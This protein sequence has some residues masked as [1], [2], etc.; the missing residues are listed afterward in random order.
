MGLP[1]LPVLAGV[2]HL[3]GQI[4]SPSSLFSHSSVNLALA[5]R[6]YK[7]TPAIMQQITVYETVLQC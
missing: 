1:A 4:N 3:E 6:S 7:H 2:L 5:S